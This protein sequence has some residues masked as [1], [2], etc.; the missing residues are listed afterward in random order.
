MDAP[1]TARGIGKTWKTKQEFETSESFEEYLKA[2]E[3]PLSKKKL[4]ETQEGVKQYYVCSYQG[5][6]YQCRVWYVA[7]A[8]DEKV[9]LQENPNMRHRHIEEQNT[10]KNCCL[11][12]RSR[13]LHR[14][15]GLLPSPVGRKTP[16]LV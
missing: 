7:L 11:N 2:M 8:H 13:R 3:V 15:F 14:F 6:L 9:S 1:K 16:E 4:H 10:E 12:I 5:C